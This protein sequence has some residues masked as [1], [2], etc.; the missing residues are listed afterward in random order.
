MKAPEQKPCLP[1]VLES[2][3]LRFIRPIQADLA[4]YSR[5]F[6]DQAVMA[7]IG[8]AQTDHQIEARLL[9]HVHHWE[10]HGFGPYVV[11]LRCNCEFVGCASL[12]RMDATDEFEIELGY[13][14]VPEFWN[15]GLATDIARVLVDLGFGTLRVDSIIA[16][17]LPINTASAHVIQ[18]V[19]F[20]YSCEIEAHNDRQ[21]CYR[22]T[23]KDWCS[24]S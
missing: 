11:Q 24:K 22:L 3:R 8:G 6:R 19:G 2:G 18:K 23:R 12:Y 9:K 13:A 4:S 16:M 7:T 20:S 14:L 5:I 21:F 1:D 17:T 10:L 15:Q